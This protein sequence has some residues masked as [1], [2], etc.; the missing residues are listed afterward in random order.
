M[1]P[2]PL[3][4]NASGQ[5]TAPRQSFPFRLVLPLGQL[6]LCA[7]LILIACGPGSFIGSMPPVHRPISA[8]PGRAGVLANN[9]VVLLNLPGY[10]LQ[11]PVAAHCKSHDKGFRD[12]SALLPA[13]GSAGLCSRCRCGG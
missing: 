10:V 2:S 4:E 11:A 1:P 7:A 12:T 3:T 5:T 13:A 8:P 6:L 9:L